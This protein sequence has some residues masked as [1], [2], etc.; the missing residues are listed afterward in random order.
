MPSHAETFLASHTCTSSDE[1][2]L[3]ALNSV[4]G[5]KF[6]LPSDEDWRGLQKAVGRDKFEG[7]RNFLVEHKTPVF[8]LF[9]DIDFAHGSLGLGYV[10]DTLLPAIL[11]GT[12]AAVDC[13]VLFQDVI[14]AVS[15]PKP[16]GQLVKTGVHLHWHQ[17]SLAGQA[18][19][20][21]MA[22]DSASAMAIRASVLHSLSQL[23]DAGLN[24][25]DV[26]DE[27]VLKQ[28]GIRLLF[29]SKCEPCS[30][31]LAARRDASKQHPCRESP[32]AASF[33]RCTCPPCLEAR[34]FCQVCPIHSSIHSQCFQHCERHC[35][36]TAH[37]QHCDVDSMDGWRRQRRLSIPAA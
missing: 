22:V 33:W 28:N 20:V 1:L 19:P 11:S 3:V 24:M 30:L 9:F 27:R 15:P 34:K 12:A 10:L 26:V 36:P 5:G 32:K 31:C 23:P 16:K 18:A 17:I 25:E 29:S 8:K 21:S 7:N 6:Q 13:Q 4:H 14:V 37:G 35:T 2:N